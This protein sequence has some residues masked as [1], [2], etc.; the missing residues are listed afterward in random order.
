MERAANRHLRG[1]ISAGATVRLFTDAVTITGDL[2][3]DVEVVHVPWPRGLSR[4]G[5]VSFGLAYAMWA[6]R[7]AK[8]LQLTV[9][10]GD[11]IHLHG[12]AA[13]ALMSEELRRSYITVVNPHGMEEFGA[14]SAK[15]LSNRLF[16]RKM[17]RAGRHGD[18]IIA[19]DLSLVS[20]IER[21][22]RPMPGTVA[23]IPNAVDVSALAKQAASARPVA[24]EGVDY[25]IVSIGRLVQN[26]GY[27]LLAE[28]IV[29]LSLR[30]RLPRRVGWVHFG[31]GPERAKV[32]RIIG[33][34]RGR[35]FFDV[36][37]DASDDIVQSTLAECDLFVQP[38]RYEG[39]SLTTLEAMSHGR[40]IVATAV[41]GIP[42]K[43]VHGKTGYL[44]RTATVSDITS[45][46]LTA[47]LDK[48]STGVAARE[49]VTERFGVDSEL[50]SY[51]DL[52]LALSRDNTKVQGA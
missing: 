25:T 23:I 37:G 24:L 13:G 5:G 34:L 27:D 10:P 42:E 49:L 28:A 11:V 21:A 43:I 38:S 39:S 16:T 46:I 50:R 9:H 44:A 1:L 45:C 29:D 8:I 32:E 22:I 52:Y 48:R 40:Q 51:I 14:F 47:L 7:L 6:N 4:G 30:A 18:R 3:P 19:T 2:I 12:A 17:V 20:R 41:G 36:I 26:K 35:V 31:V 15:R 33:R